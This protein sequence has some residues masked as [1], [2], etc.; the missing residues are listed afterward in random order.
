MDFQTAPIAPSQ[1]YGDSTLDLGLFGS[2]GELGW[3]EFD[4]C[5]GPSD[6]RFL[7]F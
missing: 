5:V 4:S 6:D 3:A 1:M 7:L 2:Q